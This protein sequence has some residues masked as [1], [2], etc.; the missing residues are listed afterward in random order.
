MKEK[1]TVQNNTTIYGRPV[2]NTLRTL[3]K[4]LLGLHT[5]NRIQIRDIAG[6]RLSGL[7]N[8][9]I[10]GQLIEMGDFSFHA[11]T[12]FA[13]PAEVWQQSDNSFDETG[14]RFDTTSVRFDK[15]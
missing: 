13:L 7:Q 15:A 12:N 1:T 3:N 14:V 8:Q 9:N 6:V 11:K 4:M 10:D 5:A 2:S